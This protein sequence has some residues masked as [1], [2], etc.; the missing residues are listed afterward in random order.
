[1]N[2]TNVPYRCSTVQYQNNQPTS[3]HRKRSNDT[4]SRQIYQQK[5][6][7]VQTNFFLFKLKLKLKLKLSALRAFS[8]YTFRRPARRGWGIL[9][10]LFLQLSQK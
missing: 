7:H 10:F 8:F 6:S 1:V 3:S 9:D 5:L 4:V 2:N